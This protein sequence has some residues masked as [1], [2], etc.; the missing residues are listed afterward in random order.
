MYAAY[1]NVLLGVS[2]QIGQGWEMHEVMV[3][4]FG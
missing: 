4:E 2:R 1:Q 3:P